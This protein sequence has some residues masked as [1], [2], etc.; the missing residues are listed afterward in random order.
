MIAAW[1]A[2]SYV[3]WANYAKAAKAKTEAE[4]ATRAAI[5]RRNELSQDIGKLT[6]QKNVLHAQITGLAKTLS[7][8]IDVTTRTE[9]PDDAKKTASTFFVSDTAATIPPRVYIHIGA[10]DQRAEARRVSALLQPN[11]YAV[12]FIRR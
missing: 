7:D 10:D 3:G 8:C 4:H 12:P 11:G 2:L 1:I 9:S 5:A 6:Q